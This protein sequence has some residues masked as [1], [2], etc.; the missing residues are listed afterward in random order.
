MLVGSRSFPHHAYQAPPP[1]RY[2]SVGRWRHAREKDGRSIVF[3]LT[4][5]RAANLQAPHC[6]SDRFALTFD[7]L[8]LFECVLVILKCRMMLTL[9]VRVS[10]GLLFCFFKW[11]FFVIDEVWRE[12][13]VYLV[14]VELFWFNVLFWTKLSMNYT[15][16]NSYLF[17][18]IFIFLYFWFL[19]PTHM[20]N[21]VKHVFIFYYFR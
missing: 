10:V 18:W 16:D 12:I 3:C 4:V 7:V 1:V 6:R 17:L 11:F 21:F 5:L 15:L 2:W 20:I 8:W 9:P 19:S 14:I 13:I